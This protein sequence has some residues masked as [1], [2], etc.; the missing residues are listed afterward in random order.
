MIEPCPCNGC[1]ER[2]SACSDRCPKDA[3]GEFGYKA[4]K[5]RHL[6]EQKHLEANKNRF[7]SPWSPAKET[8]A[9]SYSK[10]GSYGHKQGGMQ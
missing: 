4:W 1:T 3:R 2:F 10:F 9:R 5:A 7:N 6:A 8:R